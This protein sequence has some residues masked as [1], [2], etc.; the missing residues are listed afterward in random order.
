MLRM[1]SYEP[2]H[3]SYGEAIRGGFD[4]LLDRYPE[5]FVIGQGLW[6]PWYVGNSMTLIRSMVLPESSTLL[7]LNLPVLVLL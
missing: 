1:S 6:S 4:Y 5:V 7:S 2:S 3:F